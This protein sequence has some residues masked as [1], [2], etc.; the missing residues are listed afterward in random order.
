MRQITECIAADLAEK[1]E[2]AEYQK[3]CSPCVLVDKP[4]SNAKETGCPLREAEQAHQKTFREFTKF[5]TSAGKSCS[6]PFQIQIESAEWFLAS[7]VNKTS[8]GSISIYC[9]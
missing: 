3:Q 1:Y 5:G 4:G 7:V 6:L 2:Q 9:S 8:A